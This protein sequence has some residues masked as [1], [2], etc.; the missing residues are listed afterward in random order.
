MPV[1]DHSP[2]AEDADEIAVRWRSGVGPL[3]RDFLERLSFELANQADRVVS[4]LVV[5]FAAGIA[6]FFAWPSDPTWG[7]AIGGV[8]AGLLMLTVARW[9]KLPMLTFAFVLAAAVGF[10]AAHVRAVTVA[11]PVLA[12]EMANMQ[13]EGRVADVQRQPNFARIVLQQVTID[14][15]GGYSIRLTTLGRY[16]APRVGDRISVRADLR[17][18]DLPAVPGGF[19]FQRF[20]YF[21]GIGATAFTLAPWTA[22][23]GAKNPGVRASLEGLRRAISDRILAVLP[24]DVGAVAVALITGEQS[25]ISERVQ[26][27]YRASGLA[28]LLS[29]S[30]VHMSLLA[31]VVF[32]LTRRGLAFWPYVALRTDTKKVA[33]VVAIAATAF[34]LS[35]SGMSV[36][37]VRAFMMVAV[38]LAAVLLDRRALSLRTVSWAALAVLIVYPESLIGP[39]FQM[40]FMAVIALIAVYERYVLRPHWR[41]RDGQ[42]QLVDAFKVYVGGLIVTDLVAGSVT[43]VFAAYHFSNLPTYSLAGNLLAAPVTGAWV[44]P[45]ALLALVL[46]PFGLESWPLRLMGEGVEIINGTADWISMLPEAQVHVPPMS[47]AALVLAAGGILFVCLWRGRWRWTGLAPILFALAQ[48]WLAPSPDLIVAGGSDVMAISDGGRGLVLSPGRNERFVRSVWVERYGRSLGQW[49]SD[50]ENLGLVC[51]AAGCVLSRSGGTLHIAL[52]QDALADDCGRAETIV[53]PQLDARRCRASR[54][55]DRADFRRDGAHMFWLDDGAPRVKTVRDDI[56]TRRWNRSPPR[57]TRA[58]PTSSAD[59]ARPDDPGP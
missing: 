58:E 47:V 53:A 18:V 2:A 4:W 6:V 15:R 9:L 56:G 3:V 44:M 37:A 40:S 10:F 45:W 17:P 5:A 35:I 16:G 54:V 26:E 52:T 50:K 32:V 23:E 7:L 28:H 48:P 46:M 1:T 49:S 13:I 34:Y 38:V 57:Q 19:Q 55:F 29:I 25:L 39:G 33:A 21:Q 31:A 51:D 12:R 30:G 14:G 8:G 43:S 20:L 41:D 36:P 24:G 59:K 11:A 42:W 22:K 27:T